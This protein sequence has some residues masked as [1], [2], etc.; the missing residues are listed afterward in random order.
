MQTINAAYWLGLC[1]TFVLPLLVGVVTTHVTAPG[2]Q[3]VIL[4]ALDAANGVLVE[5]LAPH[6]AGYSV[7][8]A[9]V[10]ALVGFVMSVASH[11][12]LWKPTGLS[13]QVQKNVG[14]TRKSV[15]L[16]A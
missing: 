10:F 15:N 5:Y 8:S 12:G 11:F 3:A 2:I 9:I 6:P 4:L 7:T 14:V 16:A 13:Y 1:V